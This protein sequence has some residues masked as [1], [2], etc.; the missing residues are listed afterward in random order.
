MLANR[1]I[2]VIIPYHNREQYIDEAIRSVQAQ[3][4][5]PLEIIIVNDG[6]RGSARHY[7]DRYRSEC[8]V[9]DLDT[10]VGAAAARNEGI[11]RAAGTFIAFLDDDDMWLP[12]KLEIQRRYMEDDPSCAAVH[13]AVWAFFNDQEDVLWNG[14]W[15]GP[16]TLAQALTDG[17]WV[18]LQSILIRRDVL[19]DL[20]GLDPGFPISEDRDLIIR[21]CAA[22]YRIECISEPLVRVRRQGQQSLTV[23]C[24]RTF[25]MDLKLC[26]KH[27]AHYYR[28]YGFRGF[29]SYVLEKLQIATRNTHYVE[30]SMQFLMRWVK[31]RYQVRPDF[32]E[33]VPEPNALDSAPVKTR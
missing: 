15:S 32:R 20:G 28:A 19:Q 7:L 23:D 22:G 17:Y 21:A 6:S 18:S 31:V 27:R 10:N 12:R 11:R 14:N 2:T 1:D 26:W 30:R 8:T 29:V 33:P 9:V 4:L 13:T 24:W 3:T 5:K 25:A 16:I